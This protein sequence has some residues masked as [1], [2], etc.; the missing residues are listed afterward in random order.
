MNNED[1]YDVGDIV[2]ISSCAGGKLEWVLRI[3]DMDKTHLQCTLLRDELNIV[4]KKCS[5]GIFNTNVMN[6]SRQFNELIKI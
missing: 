1:S 5:I 3:D 2:F 6:A 4:D